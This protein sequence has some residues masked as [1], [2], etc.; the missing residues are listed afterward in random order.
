MAKIGSG[1]VSVGSAAGAGNSINGIDGI[2]NV[3]T[4]ITTR[5]S[6]FMGG[7]P[8]NRNAAGAKCMP[9]QAQKTIDLANLTG[10]AYRY[11]GTPS[12][13][14]WKQTAMSEF[15]GAY[16]TKPT[17]TANAVGSGDTNYGNC[18]ITCTP[19][20]D[21][22]GICAVYI[23]PTPTNGVAG[24]V[25]CNGANQYAFRANL[26]RNYTI[27]IKDINNC[28]ANLEINISGTY[29]TGQQ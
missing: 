5:E 9:N 21:V 29:Y 28:G 2:G 7:N 17:A 19:P 13:N 16:T 23:T 1:V 15:K 10:S 3:Q 26:N 14:A 27:Y 8:A 20:A 4:N 12:T 25:S 18:T 22:G 11:N 24:W 6:T